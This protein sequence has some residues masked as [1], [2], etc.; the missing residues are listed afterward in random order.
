MGSIC[1]TVIGQYPDRLSALHRAT[2][3]ND[4]EHAFFTCEDGTA[5]QICRGG[6]CYIDDEHL[7]RIPCKNDDEIG[8]VHSHP[9]Q[10]GT[11]G[12][13]LS[14]GDITHSWEMGIDY[15][16]ATTPKIR[17]KC[18]DLDRLSSDEEDLLDSMA[19]DVNDTVMLDP[20]FAKGAIKE[21]N[22]LLDD[23]GQC[24]VD[25]WDAPGFKLLKSEMSLSEMMKHLV[26]A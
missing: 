15:V 18:L 17:L 20:P 16:C 6:D 21:W 26:D 19:D 8:L 5:T 24:D 12:E 1:D 25:L 10:S 4:K 7:E 9:D 14:P 23:V 3:R 22:D 11:F 2:R 13:Y